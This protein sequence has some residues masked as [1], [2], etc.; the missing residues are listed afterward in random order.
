MTLRDTRAVL[1]LGTRILSVPPPET[2]LLDIVCLE[3]PTAATCRHPS[4]SASSVRLQGLG[5]RHCQVCE[6]LGTRLHNSMPAHSAGKQAFPRPGI[7]GTIYV[8]SSTAEQS[9]RPA[10]FQ[11]LCTLLVSADIGR[12]AGSHWPL[13]SP[14][15]S[16]AQQLPDYIAST[17]CPSAGQDWSLA[18]TS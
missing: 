13:G 4:Y 18:Q 3:N 16:P 8:A 17:K 10:P 1:Y 11:L 6:H 5:I 7:N 9:F 12:S 2:W 14:S 15:H